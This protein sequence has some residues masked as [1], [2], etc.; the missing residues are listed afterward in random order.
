MP[1]VAA[2]P[3]ISVTT[4]EVVPLVG[5]NNAPIP[6]GKPE[7]EKVTVPVKPYIGLTEIVLV[8]PLP[9]RKMVKAGG[10]AD[11]LKSG[12]A[13]V[14]LITMVCVAGPELPMIVT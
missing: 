5:L 14:R 3:A 11:R 7:A 6:A 2:L 10:E 9:L 8:P 12:P 4:L 13:T 1:G